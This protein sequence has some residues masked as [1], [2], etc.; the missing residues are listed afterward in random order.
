MAGVTGGLAAYSTQLGFDWLVLG[1]DPSKAWT[2]KGAVGGA[3]Y[4]AIVANVGRGVTPRLG[5]SIVA[6]VAGPKG[7]TFAAGFLS[8]LLANTVVSL[9]QGAPR[10]AIIRGALPAAMAGGARNVAVMMMRNWLSARIPLTPIP[11]P[12][13]PPPP[14]PASCQ[15]LLC[16]TFAA[17]VPRPPPP[18]P[19]APPPKPTPVRALTSF[20]VGLAGLVGGAAAG[21]ARIGT[22]QLLSGRPL[23]CP[24]PGQSLTRFALLTVG[25]SACAIGAN[26][27]TFDYAWKIMMKPLPK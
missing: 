14:P 4:V 7:V 13:P 22:M 11:L 15:C 24:V 25:R 8:D 3:M 19:L 6:R 27:G 10:V 5:R 21:V 2:A 20:E 9:F 17:P 16:R 1:K 12:P 26:L 18:V 23:A